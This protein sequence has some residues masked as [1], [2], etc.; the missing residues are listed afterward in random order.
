M[1]TL[2][3]KRSRNDKVMVSIRLTVPEVKALRRAAQEAHLTQGRLVAA[4]LKHNDRFDRYLKQEQEAYASE[5]Q[6]HNRK[7]D[8]F[9]KEVH[10]DINGV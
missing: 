5:V 1:N 6:N 2:P 7:I 4:A 3:R 10:D 8:I 9:I